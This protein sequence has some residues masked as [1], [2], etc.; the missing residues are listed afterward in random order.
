MEAIW[1]FCVILGRYRFGF[2]YYRPNRRDFGRFY[3][4]EACINI[5]EVDQRW[6]PEGHHKIP[7]GVENY[8]NDIRCGEL[9]VGNVRVEPQ[10]QNPEIPTQCADWKRKLLLTKYAVRSKRIRM[11][12]YSLHEQGHLLLWTEPL[13]AFLATC[14]IRSFPVIFPQV[15]EFVAEWML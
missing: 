5:I 6:N 9:P 11:D 4:T 10:N 1:W 3:K 14:H 12:Q 7:A 2:G 15:L 13:S 8:N